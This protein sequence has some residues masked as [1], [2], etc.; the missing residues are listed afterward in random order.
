MIG[1]IVDEPDQSTPTLSMSEADITEKS[2]YIYSK[3]VKESNIEK[4]IVSRVSDKELIRNVID[5]LIAIGRSKS[6]DNFDISINC[7][8]WIDTSLKTDIKNL[9]VEKS[10]KFL[11]NDFSKDMMTRMRESEKYALAILEEGS[12]LLC[13]AKMGEKTITPFYQVVDRML[14]KDNVE[15][16][17][18]FQKTKGNINVIYYEHSPSISFTRWLGVP[19]RDAYYHQGGN[20]R[21]FGEIDGFK[22]VFE[23]TDDDIE[24]KLLKG[25][26]ALKIENNQIIFSSQ[27]SRLPISQIRVGNRHYTSASQFYRDYMLRRYELAY[28]RNEYQNIIQTLDPLF[29]AYLDCENELIKYEGGKE[30]IVIRKRNLNFKILFAGPSPLSDQIIEIDDDFLNMIHANFENQV[31]TRVFHA[32]MELTSPPGDE[33]FRIGSLEIFNNIQCPES[34][35]KLIKFLDETIISDQLL[36]DALIYSVLELL[37]DSNKNMPISY[38]FKVLK[39]R[40]GEKIVK[41]ATVAQNEGPVIEYKSSSHCNGTNEEIADIICKDLSKKLTENPFK[42]YFFGIEN[43]S[44]QVSPLPSRRM[45]TDR[46]G[47]IE[48][49]IKRRFDFPIEVFLIKIPILERECIIEMVAYLQLESI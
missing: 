42:I 13:H 30:K 24:N 31:K 22:V 4:Q 38:L 8:D 27:I 48:S 32:G 43:D 12:L 37:V 2:L 14:D 23:M 28:Y 10:V 21:I 1:R 44:K 19:E 20:N 41:P 40:I 35:K 26:G 7:A 39:D 49:L 47:I 3:Q 18:I 6:I 25:D 16:F 15:R 5:S 11:L 29:H 33:P 17:V 45:D 36:K 9:D 46:L 34:I